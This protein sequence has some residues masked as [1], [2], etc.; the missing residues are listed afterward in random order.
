MHMRRV[1]TGLLLAATV[2]GAGCKLKEEENAGASA[3][4]QGRPQ[5]PPP[6]DVAA[7]PADALRTASGLASKV[8]I[9]GLGS[10]HPGL[11]NTVTVHYTGWTPDGKMFDSSFTDGKPV[12][13]KL[14]EVIS[15]WTEALQ[16]MVVKEKRRFWIPGNLGYDAIPNSTG[17]KGM[18]V[19][20][21]ELLDI[22]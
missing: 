21:I 22:K 7:P 9:V 5:I 14:T 8:L 4:G 18:L 3:F 12:S 19:F 20:E 17:P 15:G 2:V 1:V 6:P 11:T 13:F 16:L 10:I